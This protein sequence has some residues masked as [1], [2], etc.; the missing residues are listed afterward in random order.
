LYKGVLK[1]V[2]AYKLPIAHVYSAYKFEPAKAAKVFSVSDA[3]GSNS[4]TLLDQ[5]YCTGISLHHAHGPNCR[6]KMHAKGLIL[7]Q[8]S[9]VTD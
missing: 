7:K 1:H 3:T 8:A 4:Y 9:A 5:N 6:T 2:P